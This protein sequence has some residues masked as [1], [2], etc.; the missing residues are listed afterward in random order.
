[1]TWTAVGS[2]LQTT[3]TSLTVNPA[4]VGDLFLVEVVVGSAA[5]TAACT[6]ISGGHCTWT[7]LGT[8]LTSAGLSATAAVFQ[9]VATATGSA[10]ATLTISG[11]ALAIEAAGRSFRSSVGS[12]TLDVTG[13]ISTVLPNA[14]WAT[15]TPADLGELYFGYAANTGTG[16]VAGS[17]PGFVYSVD[18]NGNGLGYCLSVSST[19]TPVWGDTGQ[20]AGIMLLLHE[21]GSTPVTPPRLVQPAPP[22]TPRPG[23]G[24]RG[25]QA[26]SGVTQ[27]PAPRQAPARPQAA[28]PRRAVVKGLAVPGVTGT[29]SAQ[30]YRSIPRRVLARA[31]VLFRPVTTVNALPPPPVNGTV[32]PGP[33]RTPPRRTM[34][35]AVVLFRPVTTVNQS[36]AAGAAIVL[37]RPH[38]I[39]AAADTINQG[40]IHVISP[41]TQTLIQEWDQ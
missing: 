39:S 34:A 32:Q 1:M 23:R 7:Q 41:Y 22:R 6:A 37:G 26:G 20:G 5:G 25:G 4:A 35:R 16:A 28:A 17:T 9:G 27:V 31:V 30:P 3:T 11:T 13:T 29:A 19:Y 36:S 38:I 10:A 21:T 15:L 14:S 24:V 18:T 40:S 8:T 12:W 33:A 2:L